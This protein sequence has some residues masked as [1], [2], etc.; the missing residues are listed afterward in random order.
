MQLLACSAKST[1]VL[2][3]GNSLT[4]TGNLPAVL[5]EL[6]TISQQACTAEMV[7]EGGATLKQRVEDGTLARVLEGSDFE[8]LVL[9]ER[10]GD[11]I[12]L[13][14]QQESRI[15]AGAAAQQLVADG[16]ARG[17][18]PV[19]LGTY[20]GFAAASEQLGKAES[21][22]AERLQI[23]TIP[24]SSHF[25]CGRERHPAL[26]WLDTDGMHPGPDLTLLMAIL[27]YRELLGEL[28]AAGELQVEA[29]IYGARSGPGRIRSPALN[30]FP[31]APHPASPTTGGQWN[32]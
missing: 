3:L 30:P 2:I 27:L 16:R 29:A 22:L 7:A 13:T 32:R 24:V 15:Q 4:Y 12:A 1:N 21:A 8:Y 18:K 10:G 6:C 31:L 5:E 19:L 11:Y 17:L 9:Q 14:D 26:R 25:V 23:S 20:Q 28:P